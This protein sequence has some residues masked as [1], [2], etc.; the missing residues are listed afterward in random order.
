MTFRASLHEWVRDTL[1][2]SVHD[3]KLP[4]RPILPAVV[5]RFISAVAE[6]THSG[7]VSLLERRVQFDVVSGNDAEA[8]EIALRLIRS[9]D[10][11]HG[12][13]G[14][15]DIGSAALLVDLEVI[16]EEIKGG[17]R[18]YRRIVDFAIAYQEPRP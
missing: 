1:D 16:P 11:F 9:L 12:P 17:G 3:A 6:M 5:Q 7:P 15:A 2:V 14:D 13:M 8:D 4:I 10:G 18:Q